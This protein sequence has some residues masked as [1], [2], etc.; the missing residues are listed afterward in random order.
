MNELTIIIIIIIIINNNT[1]V[2]I[3]SFTTAQSQCI[4]PRNYC[5]SAVNGLAS[6]RSDSPAV[7][8]KHY[9]SSHNKKP[10]DCEAQL[11]WTQTEGKCPE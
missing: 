5:N 8:Q 6:I 1:V 3:C 9:A 10:V 7:A 4:L 11:T 2:E